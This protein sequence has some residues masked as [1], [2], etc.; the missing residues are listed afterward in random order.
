V[1]KRG[2]E[3]I[4]VVYVPRKKRRN[5]REA[6]RQDGND[7]Q[8]APSEKKVRRKPFAEKRKKETQKGVSEVGAGH[9]AATGRLS[10]KKKHNEKRA[11]A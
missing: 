5:C 6:R 8:E 1:W 3:G 11:Y 9:E 7:S 4:P 2:G 10:S